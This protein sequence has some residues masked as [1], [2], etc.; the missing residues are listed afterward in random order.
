MRTSDHRRAAALSTMSQAT[1]YLVAAA[2]S[3]AFGW[4][5]DSTGWTLPMVSLLAVAI[6]QSAA[7]YGAGREEEV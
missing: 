5:R 2:G 3:V 1:A 4:L 6:I 7:G